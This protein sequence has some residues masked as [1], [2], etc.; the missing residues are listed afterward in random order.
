LLQLVA[1]AFRLHSSV[2]AAESL[3]GLSLLHLV[4]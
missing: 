3:D 4:S 2:V 1:L